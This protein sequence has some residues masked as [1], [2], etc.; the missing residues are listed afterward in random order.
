MKK[1]KLAVVG[2]GNCASSLVQGIEYYKQNPSQQ[3]IGIIH[4]K[5]RDYTI[6]DIDFVAGFDVGEVTGTSF[7]CTRSCTSP[8]LCGKAVLI[9]LSIS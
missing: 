2:V 4:E 1:V 5:L 8:N 7:S 6:H 9:L 3:V